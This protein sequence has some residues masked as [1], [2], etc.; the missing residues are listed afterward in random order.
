MLES[1][2]FLRCV[3]FNLNNTVNHKQFP[4]FVFADFFYF[5]VMLRLIKTF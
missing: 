1:A 4:A 3:I 5:F 2:F